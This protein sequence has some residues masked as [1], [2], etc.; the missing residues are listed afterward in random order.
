VYPA[1]IGEAPVWTLRWWRLSRS[2]RAGGD[3][4]IIVRVRVKGQ[5]CN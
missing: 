1:A 2:R 4:M 3:E 5:P